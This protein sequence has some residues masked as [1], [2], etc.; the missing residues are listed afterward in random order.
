MPNVEDRLP[1]GLWLELLRDAD[2]ASRAQDLASAGLHASQWAPDPYP[3]GLPQ[4]IEDCACLLVGEADDP[5][6]RRAFQDVAVADATSTAIPMRR[7]PRPSQ[8]ICTGE[9]TTG[10]LLVLISPRSPD[11]AQALRDWGDFVHLRWIAAANV[12]G[13]TTITPYVHV[14]SASGTPRFCH[15]Y[16][17]TGDDPRATYES[18][19]PRVAELLGGGPGTPAYDAW[20]WHPE[21]RIEYVNTFRRLG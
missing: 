9:R 18:M 2:P 20:A 1:G 17:M 13:Y 19:T 6:A 16:E 8:G 11:G 12:P 4:H 7:Y 14:D 21:L 10:I 5:D 3:P 15:F